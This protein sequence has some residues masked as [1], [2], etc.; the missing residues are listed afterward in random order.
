M[1]TCTW[2]EFVDRCI[3]L[4]CKQVSTKAVLEEELDSKEELNSEKELGSE[5]ETQIATNK[6]A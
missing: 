5:E 1:Q 3:L 6:G 4:G 2:E